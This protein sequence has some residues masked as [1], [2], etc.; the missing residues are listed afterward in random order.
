MR[1]D[2]PYGCRATP[3]S[4]LPCTWARALPESFFRVGVAALLLILE[5]GAAAASEPP[6]RF[7]AMYGDPT[8]FEQ[9]LAK[10]FA[11]L[12]VGHRV[13]GITVL[14]PPRGGRLDRA[15][16]PLCFGR[17]YERIILLSPDHFRRSRLPFATTRGTFETVFGDVACDETAVGS[18][19]AACPKVEESALFAKEHGVHAVLP[20]VAKFFPTAKIVPVALRIDSKREDWL[21][22]ADALA[23]LVDS[24][25]LIVQ[26]TDFSHYLSLGE[27][28]RHDQQTMNTL[29]LG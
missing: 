13:T 21:A 16:L 25:T 8:V 3:Y 23:P 15:R 7:V 19:L 24:K 29:A 22:L 2:A 20:F 1:G 17:S 18:L 12:P 6:P 27:A 11:T 5:L 14:S 9:A 26:S 28:R 10:E 4:S